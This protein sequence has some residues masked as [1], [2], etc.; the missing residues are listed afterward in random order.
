[1]KIELWPTPG[2]GVTV[3]TY[4]IHQPWYL[5]LLTWL[6]V[7]LRNL[8]SAH[9]RLMANY[10]KR[11]GWVCFYLEEAHRDCRAGCWLSLYRESEKHR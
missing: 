6:R 9:H 3:T 11:H 7:R 5:R 2:P 1:M 10:L 4:Y 8:P